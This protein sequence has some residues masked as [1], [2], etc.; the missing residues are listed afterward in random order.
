MKQ[1]CLSVCQAGVVRRLEE[2]FEEFSHEETH[3]KQ[4]FFKKNM[5]DSS[6]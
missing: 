2:I 3:Y 5:Q 4:R 1:C 6:G